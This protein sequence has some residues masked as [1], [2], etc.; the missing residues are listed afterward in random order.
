MAGESENLIQNKYAESIAADI[1]KNRAE[2]A[3][4]SEQLAQLEQDH[5]YLVTLRGAIGPDAAAAGAQETT[6]PAGAAVPAP[7]Q[8]SPAAAVSAKKA[9]AK[10][11]KA[12]KKPA[13]KTAKPNGKK[14]PSGQNSKPAARKAA[15][16]T[17]KTT[18]AVPTLGDLV[19]SLLAQQPGDPLTAADI[20]KKLTEAHPDRS[21][22]KPQVLR[23]TLDRLVGKA[24]IDKSKQRNSVLYSGR[25]ASATAA[26]TPAPVKADAGA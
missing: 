26:V 8:D 25:P 4:L 21:A 7:R 5:A 12:A 2:R 17:V 22:L 10:A 11:V 24:K 18:A 19:V 13:A 3:Q 16:G 9:P 20:Q 23:N 1:E 15:A 6:A 14:A